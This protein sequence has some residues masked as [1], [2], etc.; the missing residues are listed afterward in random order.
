MFRPVPMMRLNAVVLEKDERRVLQELGR[1]GVIHLAR[2]KA[3]PETA[4]LAPP[5][6]SAQRR[7]CEQLLA[8]IAELRRTL[9]IA[10]GGAPAR[11]PAPQTMA[12]IEE[13]LDLFE[14]TVATLGQRR[15]GLE[16][17][18]EQV[19]TVIE[20]LSSFKD[21]NLPFEDLGQ[22][23]FLHFAVGSLPERRLDELRDKVAANVVLL[24]LARSSDRQAL[25]AVTSR[26]GRFAMQTALE[27]CGFLRET[28][29]LEEGATV[30][31]V[32]DAAVRERQ[33][34]EE[35]LRRNGR[36]VAEMAASAAPRLDELEHLVRV[37]QRLLEAE[38]N[39]PRTEATVLISGWVPAAELPEVT[40]R[41][42]AL[43]RGR[44]VMQAV[45]PEQVPEDQVP[46][47]LRHPRLLRPFEMLVAGY[48]LPGYG[49]LAPTLFVAITYL[50][51]FGMMFGDVGHG[52]VLAL[53]GLAA[54]ALGRAR[55]VRDVGHLVMMAG[56]SSMIFGLLYGSCFGLES[57]R[58]HA[59]W[60]DPLEGNPLELMLVAV[61]MG[62]VVISIGLIL[63]VINHFRRREWA[64]GFLDS[65][66][67]AG[68]IFYWGTLGLIIKYAALRERGLVG[69]TVLLV[70]VLPLAAWALREPLLHALDRRARRPPRTGGFLEAALESV[71]ESFEAMLSY[72]ANTISFVRLAAYAMSHAAVLMATFVMAAEV[73]KISGA[74]GLLSVLVIIAGNL[75]AILLE[76]VIA[77]VQALRLEYYEFFGKFFSGSGQAFTP[78]RLAAEEQE[79]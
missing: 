60:R 63:N 24:P 4:P 54:R 9:G 36:A 61:G 2:A 21:V 27:Q 50:L 11:E 62:V 49:E 16:T 64:R 17:A 7:H 37:E 58:K 68:A 38:E 56:I 70:I 25:V 78:F 14:R 79:A 43:T 34:L 53:G 3:G 77:A 31:A 65:F 23:S 33:R 44:C 32:L 59:L 74:G 42:Q 75:V 8:R 29:P 48:G 28:L 10:A 47:L 15:Q 13:T 41:L 20:Q 51:M 57:F 1:M 72:M 76:G 67:V 6:R 30:A 69:L 35:E 45:P 46:V 12:Q 39:F 26:T 73:R 5:D 55:K 19:A 40:R 66:G 52:A 18:L 22:F 71:V